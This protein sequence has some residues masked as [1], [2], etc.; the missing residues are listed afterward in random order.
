MRGYDNGARGRPDGDVRLTEGSQAQIISMFGNATSNSITSIGF[1]LSTGRKFGPWGVGGNGSFLVDG[2]LLGFFGA[3]E[4]G[5]ISGIGA[6]YMPTAAPP[7]PT[8]L[9]TSPAYANHSSMWTWG[10][11]SYMDGA[12]YPLV[13]FRQQKISGREEFAFL[14]WNV[15]LHVFGI[16]IRFSSRVSRYLCT[17]TCHLGLSLFWWSC[18]QAFDVLVAPNNANKSKRVFAVGTYA[19]GGLK[20]RSMPHQMH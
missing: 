12:H 16:L 17:C 10:D 15:H 2:L 7:F 11:S 20:C 18:C 14:S 1:T 9:E 8:S 4:N 3:L 13:I 6:W 5:A 19:H